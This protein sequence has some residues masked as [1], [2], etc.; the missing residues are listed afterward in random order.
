M[1]ARAR[2][3][4]SPV[5]C[6]QAL[7]LVLGLPRPLFSPPVWP[8]LT[9]EGRQHV[10]GLQPPSDSAPPP[11]QLSALLPPLARVCRLGAAPHPTPSIVSPG[12]LG[13]PNQL[14]PPR[15]WEDQRPEVQDSPDSKHPIHCLHRLWKCS[16]HP[17]V[18]PPG[19]S[20]NFAPSLEG[21]QVMCPD[22]CLVPC[23]VA[24]LAQP[25]SYQPLLTTL[26]LIPTDPC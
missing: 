3:S 5:V 17:T 26:F 14:A 6:K 23:I 16:R 18:A 12:V 24:S 9:L 1:S 19:A 4:E 25:V 11:L 2:V 15:V 20:Q 8:E 10:V 13:R 22:S 21:I 7:P